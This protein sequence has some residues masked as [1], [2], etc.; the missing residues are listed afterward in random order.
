MKRAYITFL[1]S[2][3]LII[4][5]AAKYP[6]EVDKSR[7]GV[8]SILAY[9]NGKLLRSGTGVF[10]GEKGELFSSYSLFVGADSA[11][12][13]DPS[14]K[15]RNVE[16]LLGANDIYDCIKVRVAWDKKISS[17]SITN[18]NYSIGE[19]LYLLAYGTKKGGMIELLPI[20]NIVTVSGTPYYTFS[21]SMQE[22]YLSAPVVNSEGELV[23]LMQ[24][25][26]RN[27]TLNSYAISASFLEK[28]NITSLN[29]NSDIFKRID[30]PCALPNN[31]KDALTCLHLHGL[32]HNE[33]YYM[34]L[35]DYL[36]MFPDSYEGYLLLAE[37]AIHFDK[38]IS[39]AEMAWD[40]ALQY[41]S[42]P[43]DVYYNKANVLS[44]YALSFENDSASFVSLNDSALVCYDRAIAISAEPLYI[45]RKGLLLRELKR[46]SE[47]FECF[48]AL[49]TTNM[50]SADI[51]A[52]AATCKESLGD[53]DAAIAQLDSAITSFG[54][55][56]V[57]EMA[58]YL[59]NRGFLKH[60]MG[61][62]REAVV[63]YNLFA[64]LKEG[65]LSAHFFYIREQAEFEAKMF[66]QAM[67]DI[68]TAI[69]LSP[70]EVS[71]LVEKG[72][73]C[74]RVNM[75]DE[76]IEVLNRVIELNSEEPNAHYI[77]AC[78]MLLKGNR[79]SAKE[80]LLKAK[81]LQHPSAYKKLKEIE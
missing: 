26:E 81:E 70:Q 17:L 16:R 4:S 75:P 32:V 43:D 5:Y 25:A 53:Y 24:S 28:M 63:D 34:L 29:F 52:L 79:E 46:F 73:L 49:A 41:S 54:S 7:K 11:V 72:R 18:K 69:S 51:F 1:F 59:W 13:I 20:K 3:F 27:D 9:K 68:N 15:V 30:I 76:A 57:G 12:A 65:E 62:Y 48:D 23:A 74:Y 37:K 47:A 35:D 45:Y 66:Q 14:G 36:Q 58:G 55:V 33:K 71:Y 19:S 38:N 42:T 77:L 60:R 80:H 21:F 78:C 61:R 44:S 56:P 67:N 39:L 31:K 2:L 10:V 40:K 6:K 50:R 22:R 8:A 64:T